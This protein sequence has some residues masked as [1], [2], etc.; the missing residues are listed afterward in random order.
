MIVANDERLLAEL[1]E[2]LSTVPGVR[3][4]ALGGSRA[5]GTATPH[6]DYDIGLY[7]DGAAPLDVATLGRIAAEIDDR[8]AEATV[9][10]VGG[11]GPWIDGGGWLVIEEMRVDLLY[12]D[13]AKVA[14]VIDDC[15]AGKVEI[16]YQPGHPH[17]FVS[18]IYAGEVALCKVLH[19]PDG[20][21]AAER[22]RTTPYPEAMK[23]ELRRR[24]EWEAC[25]SLENAEKSRAR[26]DTVYIAGCAFRSIACLCQ[27]LHAANGVWLLNEKGAV[28]SVTRLQRKPASFAEQVDMVLR[29]VVEGSYASGLERLDELIAQT[30]AT[31]A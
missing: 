8:G 20:A 31:A 21:L 30:R 18:S 2:V 22:A 19:D 13:L 9:T 23:R 27:S 14:R 26:G 3:A 5:R 15:R 11:W 17:A 12:R 7:Y 25:F 10:P 28:A 6:S 4:I 16:A 29:D 24:F 1:T